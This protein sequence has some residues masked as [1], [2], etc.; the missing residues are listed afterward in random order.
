LEQV[1]LSVIST[2]TATNARKYRKNFIEKNTLII[3]R[4]VR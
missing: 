4:S 1:I 2:M 3:M